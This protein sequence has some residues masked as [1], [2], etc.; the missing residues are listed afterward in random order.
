MTTTRW[1]KLV[2]G[3]TYRYTMTTTDG[4]APIERTWTVGPGTSIDSATHFKQ[5][6]ARWARRGDWTVK[7]EEVREGP[8]SPVEALEGPEVTAGPSEDDLL[9]KG[10]LRSLVGRLERI[11]DGYAYVSGCPQA[12]RP[13]FDLEAGAEVGDLIEYE[14]GPRRYGSGYYGKILK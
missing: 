6:V 10:I 4:R 14:Y 1:P 3:K 12:L 9:R 13:G 2:E 7:V 8:Q 5:A 11:Q